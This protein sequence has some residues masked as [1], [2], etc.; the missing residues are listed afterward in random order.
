MARDAKHSAARSASAGA[1][2]NYKDATP[3]DR[4]FYLNF[5]VLEAKPFRHPGHTP[6]GEHDLG[7]STLHDLDSSDVDR[8]FSPHHKNAN[9][10]SRLPVAVQDS[11]KMIGITAAAE[12][13]YRRGSFCAL[14]LTIRHTN[15]TIMNSHKLITLSQLVHSCTGCQIEDPDAFDDVLDLIR[16]KLPD[17]LEDE[18]M[19]V[20]LVTQANL[21]EE[22]AYIE[23]VKKFINLPDG[24]REYCTPCTPPTF[25]CSVS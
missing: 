18:E 4:V 24:R 11:L 13:M 10:V 12:Q 21:E 8:I 1:P 17:M 20:E 23:K 22:N 16:E 6:P 7:F 14:Q 15:E 9:K 3:D 19:L 25:N 5:L 2:S